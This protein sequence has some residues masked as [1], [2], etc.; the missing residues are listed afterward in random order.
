M[1]TTDS[2]TG[3]Y[4]KIPPKMTTSFMNWL[5]I[6]SGLE[7][8]EFSLEVTQIIEDLFQEIESEYAMVRPKDL[9]PR[10]VNLFL[11]E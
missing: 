4:R 7:T 10:F 11:L 8:H 9:D 5:S 1:G 3:D 6:S 2:E